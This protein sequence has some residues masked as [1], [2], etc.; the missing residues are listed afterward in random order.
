MAAQDHGEVQKA[1]NILRE[2]H[3]T[4]PGLFAV[5]ESLGLLYV[6]QERFAEALPLLEAAARENAQS[7]A[8]HANLGA[9]YFQLKRKADAMEQFE[10][11]ARLNPDNAATQQSLGRL[12]M[13]A[14]HPDRAAA[15]FAE[16]RR[17]QPAN[18]DAALDEAV[19]LQAAGETAKAMGVLN[20]MPGADGSAAAQVLLGELSEKQNDV[21]AAGQHFA[22][23][24][25][26]DPS[27][28]N[29]WEL[30]VEFLRHWSFEPAIREFEAAVVRFPQSTR[31]RLGLGAAY[32]GNGN[33]AKALPVFADLLHDDANNHLYADLLGMSCL[34]E[35]HEAQ[36]RCGELVAYAEAH[37]SD[38][39]AATYAASTLVQSRTSEAESQL[40]RQLLDRAI[41]ADPKLAEAYYQRG[42]LKQLQADWKGSIPDLEAAIQRKPNFAKAHYRLALACWRDGRK[43]DAQREM[44]LQQKFSKQ[45]REDLDRQLRQITVFIVD[46]GQ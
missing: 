15:A 1:E 29:V 28:Q 21:K 9:A 14:H 39:M 24:V 34:A 36:P 13:D 44:D 4:H 18:A 40:A 12:W 37:P 35:S 25:E 20:A 17:L 10:I 22:R 33:Y 6:S 19:A 8:A 42:L 5:N 45:Q 2:L 41:K 26:L 32:F 11:A 3:S 23:A 46:K 38:A 27:E 30:G 16:V 7:D 43:A 31:M